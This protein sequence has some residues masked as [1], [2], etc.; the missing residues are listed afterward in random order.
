MADLVGRGLHEA[1]RAE[2]VVRTRLA[3][4]H[5]T[6]EA[7]ARCRLGKEDLG[8]E[9]TR[10]TSSTPAALSI[11]ASGPDH[12]RPRELRDDG[13][14]ALSAQERLETVSAYLLVGTG[15]DRRIG[16]VG[17]HD[18]R[19]GP[20]A[21]GSTV[22]T[23]HLAL[24]P[25]GELPL[26]DGRSRDLAEQVAPLQGLDYGQEVPT[27][28][29]RARSDEL[30]IYEAARRPGPVRAR[31]DERPTAE[32]GLRGETFGDGL[33]VVTA[34]LYALCEDDQLG[35][36]GCELSRPGRGAD[37]ARVGLLKCLPCLVEAVGGEPLDGR[38]VHGV[39]LLHAACRLGPGSAR[40]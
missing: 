36:G 26:G 10:R 15:G 39:Q 34:R 18:E 33:A 29:H 32:V 19:L 28:K 21:G 24:T 38:C 6:V 9:H 8:L 30:E 27:G 2:V 40:P 23:G 20:A 35:S 5:P 16:A 12:V 25:V 11:L 7:D 37:N 22:I 4:R 13:G 31:V 17:A 14:G 3:A 1:P